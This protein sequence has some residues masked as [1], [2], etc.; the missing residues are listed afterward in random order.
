VRGRL[1]HEDGQHGLLPP[2]SIRLMTF[3]AFWVDQDIDNIK[4]WGSQ[5]A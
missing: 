3:G 2:V 5:C 1:I 4:A